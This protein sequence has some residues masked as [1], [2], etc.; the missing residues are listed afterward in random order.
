MAGEK[1]G[2]PEREADGA[3][4]RL[5]LVLG[6]QLSPG[7]SS[8][9]CGDPSR[10]VVL[11][12]EVMEEASYV[13]H[14]VKKIAFVFSAMR[15]FAEEL[16]QSGWPVDYGTLDEPGS[17]GTLLGEVE[18]ALGRHGLD[19]AVATEPGEW[20]LLDAM[21]RWGRID[22]LPDDRFLSDRRGFA[23]W[24]EGRKGLRLEHFYRL[25]RRKT[26]LLMEGD[27]PAGGQWNYDAENRKPAAGGLLMPSPLRCEPDG[28]TRAVLDLC[29][30]R[31]PQHFGHL[32]PY[33]FAPTRA[34][35]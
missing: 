21:Q 25:M 11:M 9:T 12:A 3:S 15:H 19:R 5:I 31:F 23:E 33:W 20:R 34:Q 35:A 29:A 24:A 30:S 14:H 10:A 17:A 18:R 26:G 2:I 27:Q 1:D 22:L 28:I 16:R 4:A 13:R 7:L 32:E 8:L 6:D